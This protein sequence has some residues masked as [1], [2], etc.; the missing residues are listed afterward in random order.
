MQ[1][2][3]KTGNVHGLRRFTDRIWR[4]LLAAGTAAVLCV[5]PGLASA[6]SVNQSSSEQQA[7]A[8]AAEEFS[9]PQSVLQAISYN[10]SRWESQAGMSVDG[11]YGVMDLRTAPGQI[12]SGRDGSIKTPAKQPADYY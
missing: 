6:A 10:E 1:R 7:F 9:V 2:I 3:H 8:A 4:S 12:Q 11:G 5:M